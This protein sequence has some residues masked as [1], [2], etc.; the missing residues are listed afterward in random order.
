MSP[1]RSRPPALYTKAPFLQGLLA[2]MPESVKVIDSKFRVVYAN[3]SAQKSIDLPLNE[4]RGR[5]CHQVFYGFQ[6]RCFFCG[7]NDVF[8]KKQTRV[9]YCTLVVDKTQ[10]EF[11]V[12]VYPLVSAHSKVDYAVEI[13]RDV[14]AMVRGGSLP[15]RAGKVFTRDRA[16]GLAF[17]QMAQMALDDRPV[18]IEGENG[19]GKKS[20]AR[21]LHQRS[22]RA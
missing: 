4:I 14:T 17:E 21:A 1:R 11:E 8:E 19:T 3:E 10:R 16:F 7:M 18:L 12:S 20:L 13:V 2:G 9:Q 5:L 15:Q 22:A 6:E